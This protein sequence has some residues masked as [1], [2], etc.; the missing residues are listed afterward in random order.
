MEKQK[1]K[2][3]I[4]PFL[5]LHGE[6]AEE[7]CEEMRQI[8]AAG[9]TAVC[10]ESRTHEAFGEQAWFDEMDVVL[11]QAKEHHMK[12]WLLDDKLFPTGFA[13]GLAMEKYPQ[14]LKQFMRETHVDVLEPLKGANG[15]G[16]AFK[17]NRLGFFRPGYF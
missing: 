9:I 11:Q 6:S 10:V 13:N 2:N 16:G 17:P 15:E 1:I 7:I 8:R 14:Y 12:V 3:C 4:A 5:W